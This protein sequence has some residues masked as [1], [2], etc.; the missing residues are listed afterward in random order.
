MVEYKELIWEEEGFLFDKS[1]LFDD[2]EE[3]QEEMFIAGKTLEEA[4]QNRF[5]KTTMWFSKWYEDSMFATEEEALQNAL[6]TGLPEGE[7][8]VLLE[9]RDNEIR[10][11]EE[12]VEENPYKESEAFVKESMKEKGEQ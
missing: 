10:G 2:S 11:I 4:L 3:D 8:L 5:I 12:E 1:E 9:K 7:E 6:E